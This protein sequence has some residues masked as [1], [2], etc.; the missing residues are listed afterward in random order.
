ME[1]EAPEMHESTSPGENER[2]HSLRAHGDSC[3]A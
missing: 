3:K 2:N 1:E